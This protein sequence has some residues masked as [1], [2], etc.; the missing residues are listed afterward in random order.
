VT[1]NDICKSRPSQDDVASDFFD[2]LIRVYDIDGN[3][4]IEEP[5]LIHMLTTLGSPLND[6][7]IHNR[8]PVVEPLHL[9][10]ADPIE[11]VVS[12]VTNQYFYGLILTKMDLC[13][14]M[15]YSICS[16]RAHC[17]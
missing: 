7:Q 12:F 5:E 3:G 6:D 10:L 8:T 2:S 17:R 15:N 1:I 16:R 11:S 9:P 4:C 13:R 14:V